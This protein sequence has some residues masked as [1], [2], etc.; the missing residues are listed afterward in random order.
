MPTIETEIRWGD[1]SL[2]TPE[3]KEK[4]FDAI[5]DEMKHNQYEKFCDFIQQ[6]FSLMYHAFDEMDAS[7]LL[8][9]ALLIRVYGK[10]K[11]LYGQHVEEEQV[12]EMIRE[13]RH[14]E[15]EVFYNAAKTEFAQMICRLDEEG[16]PREKIME[17]LDRVYEV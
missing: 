14:L 1:E 4:H 12:R 6:Q 2:V 13:M 3:E 9:R 8:E 17:I 16:V 15:K 10:T 7:A 11:L 5:L